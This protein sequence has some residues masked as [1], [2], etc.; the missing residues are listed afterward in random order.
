MRNRVTVDFSQNS[1]TPSIEGDGVIMLPAG[2]GNNVEKWAI[3]LPQDAVM[4]GSDG[5]VYSE[6]AVYTGTRP[7]I[8]SISE[9]EYLTDGIAIIVVTHSG[10]PVGAING[11]FSVS[12]TK[13]VYFSKGNLQ[14]IGSASTP[15]WQFAENQWDYIGSFNG[16]TFSNVDRD[17]FGW[18]TSGYN[19]GAICYQPWDMDVHSGRYYAYGNPS[20]N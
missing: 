4:E 18:G 5:S 3:L 1:V 17:L 11:L 8:S 20:Y 16:S 19:H 12:S 7:A 2:S 15:Y 6:D 13:Q 14:Y 10:V 9:N